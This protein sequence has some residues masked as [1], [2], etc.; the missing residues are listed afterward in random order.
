MR[1][2]ATL[3]GMLLVT[4]ASPL[5]A[6]SS[7]TVAC[8]E[9][10]VFT[11]T[12][13]AN[14]FWAELSGSDSREQQLAIVSK[15]YGQIT[16]DPANINMDRLDRLALGE[17]AFLTF[18]GRKAFQFFDPLRSGSD[19]IAEHAWERVMQ[20]TFRGFGEHTRAEALMKEHAVQF[21]PSVKNIRGRSQIIGNFIGLHIENGQPEKAVA[22]LIDELNALPVDAPYFSYG[23]VFRNAELISN[24]DRE[25]EIVDLVRR[26]T[27]QLRQLSA[28]WNVQVYGAGTDP[29]LSQE[30]PSWF[31]K[32]QGVRPGESLRAARKRQL[33]GLLSALDGWLEQYPR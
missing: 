5:A 12:Q 29:I 27:G 6:Q 25:Q 14:A 10:D 24:S 30:M 11:P 9:L 16:S 18:S 23:L 21:R 33:N 3:T 17:G 22:L 8:I 1:H 32:S 15:Y 4:S 28:N 19:L 26:K 7:D 31:W 2:L 13:V 20:I